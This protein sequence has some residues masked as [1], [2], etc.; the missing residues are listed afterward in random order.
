MQDDSKSPKK[1]KSNNTTL[2]NGRGS[3]DMPGRRV[4]PNTKS[5]NRSM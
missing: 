1:D 4:D 2:A 3:G 5:T